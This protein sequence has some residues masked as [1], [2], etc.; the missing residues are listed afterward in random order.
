[1]AAVIVS[2]KS[3]ITFESTEFTV[4]FGRCDVIS[5]RVRTDP[6]CMAAGVKPVPRVIEKENSLMFQQIV[7]CLHRRLTGGVQP[8][9]ADRADKMPVIAGI[10]PATEHARCFCKKNF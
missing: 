7:R 3:I 9:M 5:L 10:D 2:T 6:S 4:K 8:A 1:M